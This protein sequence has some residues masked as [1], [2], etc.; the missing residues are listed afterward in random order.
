MR[1][2]YI[3]PKMT[4]TLWFVWLRTTKIPKCTDST[5]AKKVKWRLS[6]LSNIRPIQTTPRSAIPFSMFGLEQRFCSLLKESLSCVH[7]LNSLIFFKNSN[8][9][10]IFL[11][12][13]IG[14][15]QIFLIN[16]INNI[17]FSKEENATSF[18]TIAIMSAR[19]GSSSASSQGVVPDFLY[20]PGR[21]WYL[22]LLLRS[23][24]KLV[25][26]PGDKIGFGSGD[27]IGF[28][29]GVKIGLG[30]GDNLVLGS[31]DKADLR[32]DWILDFFGWGSPTLVGD[33][34]LR[35]GLQYRVLFRL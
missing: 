33:L 30:S 35:T 24:D 19:V 29:S 21:I 27:K 9:S 16:P 28:G 31:G 8:F 10:Y 25:L 14:A 23:G 7:N 20:V 1:L 32:L 5:T 11:Y 12:F 4:G 15:W 3:K 18:S 22:S 6:T 13:Q 34:G 17:R 2:V 26:G